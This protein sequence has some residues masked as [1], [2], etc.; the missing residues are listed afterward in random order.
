MADLATQLAELGYA[1]VINPKFAT[2][3]LRLELGLR[4]FQTYAKLANTA[5]VADPTKP[6]Y[7]DRLK[8]VPLP[9]AHKLLTESVTGAATPRTLE[10]VQIWIDQKYRCPVVI[11]CW[12]SEQTTV[13][14]TPWWTRIGTQKGKPADRPFG[15][16]IWLWDDP[17]KFDAARKGRRMYVRDFSG[18]FDS[19]PVYTRFVDPKWPRLLLGRQ[20]HDLTA[21]PVQDGPLNDK[22]SKQVAVEVTPLTLTGGEYDALSAEAKITYRVIRAVSEAECQGFFDTINCWDK[23]LVS[24]GLCHW[25]IAHFDKDRN[26]NEVFQRGEL[27]ALLAYAKHRDPAILRTITGDTGVEPTNGWHDV[28]RTILNT[29]LRKYESQFSQINRVEENGKFVEKLQPVP[30]NRDRLNFFRSW[31]WF[32]RFEMACRTSSDLHR[33]M[34]DMARFRLQDI[35][36]A[37]VG[38]DGIKNGAG[39]PARF[40][41]VF[42]CEQS[43]VWLMEWHVLAPS[44]VFRAGK[45]SDGLKSIINQSGVVLTRPTNT[46]TNDDEQKL[47]KSIKAKSPAPIKERFKLAF[48]CSQ[49]REC[50]HPDAALGNPIQLS[51][52]RNSFKLDVFDLETSPF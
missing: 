3:E 16:N 12:G 51:N 26:G 7:G 6:F 2:P 52:A 25:T 22:S 32:Y 10:L 46:W 13:G 23:A 35:R 45:A 5:Q 30:A 48:N 21:T 49:L 20:N 39:E 1:F 8:M 31:H 34:W 11:E 24:I 15:E 17:Q 43:L 9:D 40:G 14:K 33:R 36:R 38:I 27:E 50:K 4:E 29:D 37:P 18:R 41:D 47:L 42:T 44:D 19:T 28:D